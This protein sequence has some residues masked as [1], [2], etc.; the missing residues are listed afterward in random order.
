MMQRQRGWTAF[1]REHPRTTWWRA[2]LSGPVNGS[3]DM[4]VPMHCH[5]YETYT[6]KPS[7]R[8]QL[9]SQNKQVG[10]RAVVYMQQRD[11]LVV[12]QTVDHELDQKHS[13]LV[14]CA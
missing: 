6:L 7:Y 9:S 4:S 8:Q 3:D 14:L 10:G 13:Q 11:E 2:K 12:N 1:T 5:L